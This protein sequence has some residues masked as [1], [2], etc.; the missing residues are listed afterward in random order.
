[1]VISLP[2][3]A[4]K[5]TLQAELEQQLPRAEFQDM[6]NKLETGE[7]HEGNHM[8]AAKPQKLETSHLNSEWLMLN[9][10]NDHCSLITYLLN[11][12]QRSASC[13]ILQALTEYFG[14]NHYEKWYLNNPFVLNRCL[15]FFSYVFPCMGTYLNLKSNHHIQDLID[16][17]FCATEP[18]Y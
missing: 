16:G 15:V 4:C 1:M 12:T 3:S 10:D 13:P 7:L 17:N 18:G 14:Y 6:K 11:K 8:V 9:F 2:K 5:V